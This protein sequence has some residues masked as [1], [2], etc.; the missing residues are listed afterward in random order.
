MPPK[1]K[2][3]NALRGSSKMA[4]LQTGSKPSISVNSLKKKSPIAGAA[5]PDAETVTEVTVETSSPVITDK[6]NETQAVSLSQ[7][8]DLSVLPSDIQTVKEDI[9][10]ATSGETVK[11]LRTVVGRSR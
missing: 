7:S 5:R 11:K 1:K 8:P 2:H 6:E 4:R 9:T 10:P 3:R